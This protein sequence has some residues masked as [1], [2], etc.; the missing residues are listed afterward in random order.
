[1]PA[2]GKPI[3][4]EPRKIRKKRKIGRAKQFPLTMLSMIWAKITGNYHC[5]AGMF[6]SG[7]EFAA[8]DKFSVTGL[9]T[10]VSVFR[11][12]IQDHSHAFRLTFCKNALLDKP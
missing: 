2:N 9:L 7:L 10:D 3:I 4:S 5:S 6:W 1:M 8:L 12:R 11:N